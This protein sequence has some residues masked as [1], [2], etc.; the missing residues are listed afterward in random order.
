M[1]HTLTVTITLPGFQELDNERERRKEL[2]TEVAELKRQNEQILRISN[3]MKKE[4]EELKQLEETQ[5][6]NVLSLRYVKEIVTYR[7]MG[8]F[9]TLFHIFPPDLF[10]KQNYPTVIHLLG[11]G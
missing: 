2:E 7:R 9:E 3:I 6:N 11:T 8:I 10:N 4:L 5:R 1:N